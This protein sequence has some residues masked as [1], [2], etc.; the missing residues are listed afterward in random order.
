MESFVLPTEIGKP[1]S[2]LTDRDIRDSLKLGMLLNKD[3]IDEKQIRQA[4][5]E[6]RIGDR[7]TEFTTNENGQEVKTAL[8]NNDY[9]EIHPGQTIF[10]YSMEQFIIPLNVLARINVLGQYFQHGLIGGNTYADPGF[11]NFLYITLTNTSNRSIRLKQG[12]PIAKVEFYKLGSKVG[13]GHSGVPRDIQ[14][15]KFDFNSS[16]YNLNDSLLIALINNPCKSE[17]EKRV[18]LTELVMNMR[19]K[20]KNFRI[21]SFVAILIIFIYAQFSLLEIKKTLLVNFPSISEQIN[22]LPDSA[23]ALFVI[24]LLFLGAAISKDWLNCYI[25]KPIRDMFDSTK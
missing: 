20:T 1:S 11:S 25:V 3:T 9:F 12:D 6:I 14:L 16:I 15:E 2:V 5:Y 21:Y 19:K 13:H 7:A 17:Y 4:S 18:A 8:P 23:T 24:I 10:I 22:K